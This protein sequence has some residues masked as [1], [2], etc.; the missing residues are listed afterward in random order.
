MH[1]GFEWPRRFTT[2]SPGAV[3]P[4]SGLM[5][6]LCCWRGCQL[7]IECSCVNA[8]ADCSSETRQI[9][10]SI[11]STKY[12]LGDISSVEAGETSDGVVFGSCGAT[13]VGIQQDGEVVGYD[14]GQ[15]DESPQRNSLV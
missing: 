6:F 9:E 7:L 3:S 11:W 2:R 15:G 5:F 14:C 12:S 8:E 13:A 1:A 4:L 10:V